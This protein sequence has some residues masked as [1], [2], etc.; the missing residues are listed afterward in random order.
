[1]PEQSSDTPPTGASGDKHN[2]PVSPEEHKSAELLL[3]QKIILLQ[4]QRQLQSVSNSL[5]F[6]QPV[7]R[8]VFWTP[9][10]QRQRWGDADVLP[11][12]NWGDL[13][14][15]LFYVAGESTHHLAS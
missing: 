6:P 15:D 9:P 8:V 10:K 12:I 2:A 3:Q 13:F 7:R 4:R 11:H 14:F 5:S 1:M